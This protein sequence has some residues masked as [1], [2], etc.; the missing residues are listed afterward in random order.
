MEQL[1]ILLHLLGIAPSE[2]SA[3]EIAK[4]LYIASASASARLETF[5][6]SG[7][8]LATSGAT[9]RYRLPPPGTAAHERIME[10]SR[11]Y[12][13]RRVS[14]INFIFSNPIAT[15]Q[16]FADAFIVRKKEE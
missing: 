10:L 16:S 9:P 13:E 7:L 5:K 8:V 4:S 6:A 14:V 11:I 1:E 15:I 2:A 12:R 3:D